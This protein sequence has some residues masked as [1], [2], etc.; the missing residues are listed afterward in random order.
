MATICPITN[1][2]CP[3]KKQ[4]INGICE[5]QLTCP[6]VDTSFRKMKKKKKW[7]HNKKFILISFYSL[8]II[9]LMSFTYIYFFTNI[10]ISP[11]E[12]ILPSATPT[13]TPSSDTGLVVYINNKLDINDTYKKVSLSEITPT[14]EAATCVKRIRIDSLSIYADTINV[15]L[16]KYNLIDTYPSKDIISWYEN[17]A[18]PGE[19][20][21]CI[22][23]GNKYYNNFTAV[24]NNLDKIKIHDEI[25]FTL[26]NGKK[27][28]QQV[29]DITYYQGN[30]LP[31]I[32]LDLDTSYTISTLISRAGQ[33]NRET[34]DFDSFIVVKAH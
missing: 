26:D 12:V 28:T 33:Y 4:L 31:E 2:R 7:F 21:N 27:I 23:L 32:V 13:K 25:V 11:T 14:N 5:D 15:R 10:I 29:Y 17:S 30:I 6:I 34:G 3:Y 20:G 16:N 24:F 8:L 9:L 19:L 22:L 18:L 1:E